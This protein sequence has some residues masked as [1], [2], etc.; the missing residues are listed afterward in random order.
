MNT[1]EIRSV[2]KITG[3]EEDDFLVLKTCLIMA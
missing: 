2:N 1:A 3:P